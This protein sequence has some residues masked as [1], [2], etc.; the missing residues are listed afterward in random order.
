MDRASRGATAES[1]GS[2]KLYPYDQPRLVSG[3]GPASRREWGELREGA[4]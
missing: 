4:L 3:G 2:K 1:H